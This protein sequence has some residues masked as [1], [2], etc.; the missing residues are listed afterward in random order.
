MVPTIG[1]IVYLI[2]GSQKMTVVG[3]SEDQVTCIWCPYGHTGPPNVFT[4]PAFALTVHEGP[5]TSRG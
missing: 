3:V 5:R 2:S 4:F 1:S